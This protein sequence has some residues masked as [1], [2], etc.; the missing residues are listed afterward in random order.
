MRPIDDVT[1]FSARG[2]DGAGAPPAARIAPCET[3]GE[4]ATPDAAIPRPKGS[5]ARQLGARRAAMSAATFCKLT[6][7]WV[8]AV[9]LV[10]L[11]ALA[12]RWLG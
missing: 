3:S 10:L 9:S 8:G 5:T 6:A 11:A 2:Q 4:R 7:V 12:M 1:T